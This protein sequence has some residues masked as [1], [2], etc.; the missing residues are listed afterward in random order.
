MAYEALRHELDRGAD[1]AEARPHDEGVK[2]LRVHN[3]LLRARKKTLLLY[4]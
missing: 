4:L 3:K 1:A 2:S